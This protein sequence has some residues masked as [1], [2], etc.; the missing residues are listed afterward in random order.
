MSDAYRPMSVAR[1]VKETLSFAP[2]RMKLN[3]LTFKKYITTSQIKGRIKKLAGKI[4]TDYQK[5]T[6]LLLPVLN[7]SFM[8]AA[9]LMKELKMPC[10]VSFVKHASYE[11]TSSTSLKTLIGLS[12]SVFGLDIIVV[13]DI[14]DTGETLSRVID[15]LKTL[16]AKSVEIAVLLRKAKAK[17]HTLKPKY[18]GF[19]IADPFVVGYGLDYEGLGRNF[20]DVYQL[21]K[22]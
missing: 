19:E 21:G 3:D 17:K 12:E 22:P 5:K 6:P 4:N 2:Q 14:M 10:K 8:F 11:G 7:G 16:G 15:E 1:R 20:P 13:E 18:I 9:D